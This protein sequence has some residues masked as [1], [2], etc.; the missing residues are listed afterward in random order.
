MYC[1]IVIFYILPSY[2]RKC[3]KIYAN[4][5]LLMS[6][7]FEEPQHKEGQKCHLFQSNLTE[8]GKLECCFR[9]AWKTFLDLQEESSNVSGSQTT[10]PTCPVPHVHEEKEPQTFL[11]L[12]LHYLL[13]RGVI[14][15]N[16]LPSQRPV[17]RS[18]MNF[19]LG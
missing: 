4:V 16:V 8:G 3:S 15:T 17:V 14:D 2:Y 10:Q 6:I 18:H 1:Y 12:I 9:T 19:F 13:G 5:L 11:L 7:S